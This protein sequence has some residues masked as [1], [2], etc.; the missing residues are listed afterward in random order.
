MRITTIS[1][2]LPLRESRI[3][4]FKQSI[5]DIEGLDHELYNNKITDPEGHSQNLHRYPLIQYRVFE[6]NAT[7]W[8]INDGAKQLEADLKMKVIQHFFWQG[9]TE[10]FQLVRHFSHDTEACQYLGTDK[11]LR[12]R[13]SNYLPLSNHTGGKREMSTYDEYENART[14]SEK[15]GIIERIIASHLVLFSY[16]AG[17]KL[18][19]KQR[20]KASIADIK[21]IS[22]GVYKKGEDKKEKYFKKFDLI[23]DINA[24]L[25]DGIALGNQVALGYGVVEIVQDEW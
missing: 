14:L 13:I 1:F 10:T 2:N 9:Q 16:A 22:F 25:A 5:L 21:D 19:K 8:A 24:R 7:I 6:D 20:L 4:L 15:I 11:Y 12:Y 18:T 23:V 3:S 17:W